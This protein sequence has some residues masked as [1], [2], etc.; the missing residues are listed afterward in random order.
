M[1]SP[2]STPA[3]GVRIDAQ[4]GHATISIDGTPL[5]AGQVIGYE[6]QHYIAS[7]LP[8]LVLHVRQPTGTVWEG[9]ARVAVADPQHDVG[10]QI[11]SFVSNLNPAAVQGAALERDDL[12]NDRTSVTEAI[13]KTITDWAQGRGT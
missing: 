4:P 6:L 11:A 3:H 10:E 9:L 8:M 2:A 5:P 7:S 13:L 12:G 1:T